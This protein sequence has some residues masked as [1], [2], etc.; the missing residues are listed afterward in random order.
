VNISLASAVYF[1][2]LGARF[3]VEATCLYLGSGAG[4]SQG[5]RVG[6][7]GVTSMPHLKIRLVASLFRSKLAL[8]YK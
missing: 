8:S 7:H 6:R 5:R 3:V 2:K 4:P 1:D